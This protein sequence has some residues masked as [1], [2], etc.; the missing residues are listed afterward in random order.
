MDIFGIGSAVKAA[1][2]IYFN[3]ARRSGRTTALI[4]TLKPGDRVY[5]AN[6]EMS[7]WFKRRLK[8]DGVD[9]VECA[10]WNDHAVKLARAKGRAIFDHTLI[11]DLYKKAIDDKAK[12]I[13]RIEDDFSGV[14][15]VIGVD[16]QPERFSFE[17]H[18]F[19]IKRGD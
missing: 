18:N 3:C 12:L 7:Q 17:F 14:E 5:F 16:H 11:E 1:A 4:K 8:A 2:E 10:V 19:R 9:G 15:C 6:Y 13:K